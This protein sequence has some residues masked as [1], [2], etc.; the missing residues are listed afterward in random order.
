MQEDKMPTPWDINFLLTDCKNQS[1]NT[2]QMFEKYKKI[3]NIVL[4]LNDPAAD[5]IMKEIISSFQDMPQT[6]T[7]EEFASLE[8]KIRQ[9]DLEQEYDRLYE[10]YLQF[11][12]KIR[13]YIANF[14]L[15]QFHLRAVEANSYKKEFSII[16]EILEQ[17]INLPEDKQYFV[18]FYL[19][20]FAGLDLQYMSEMPKIILNYA[21]FLYGNSGLLESNGNPK[22]KDYIVNQLYLEL[23]SQIS[24]D[25]IENYRYL[26]S[27]PNN[28]EAAISYFENKT[29]NRMASI[30]L[31]S[32]VIDFAY[33]RST[34]INL[35]RWKDPK[36]FNSWIA[37]QLFYNFINSQTPDELIFIGKLRAALISDLNES[38]YHNILTL[39]GAIQDSPDLK[40]IK[41]LYLID[42]RLN[43]AIFSYYFD[44]LN[45]IKTKKPDPQFFTQI[46]ST[47]ADKIPA[48]LEESTTNDIYRIMFMLNANRLN[49]TY[50]PD[51]LL[52]L[53][54]KGTQPLE[55][56]DIVIIAIGDEIEGVNEIS[57]KL[58][59]TIIGVPLVLTGNND[60]SLAILPNGAQFITPGEKGT[61]AQWGGEVLLHN[62]Y[63][64]IN[65]DNK[66]EF[67]NLKPE[68]IRETHTIEEV[69]MKLDSL[70]YKGLFPVLP[71]INPKNQTIYSQDS[72][73][74]QGKAYFQN[75]NRDDSVSLLIA[76]DPNTQRVLTKYLVRFS[77]GSITED[78]IN[79]LQNWVLSE[80][81]NLPK[82]V[83]INI[84]SQDVGRD[85]PLVT[86][87]N[88][89]SMVTGSD[90]L[91]YIGFT[92]LLSSPTPK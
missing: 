66:W 42:K 59:G 49:T 35:S 61:L 34:G 12:E 88:V 65:N 86:K 70:G 17:V 90:A 60:P 11:P 67:R 1:T 79:Q 21:S 14:I 58:S 89:K 64:L 57:N 44:T 54:I 85:V 15:N 7:K 55:Q 46:I 47:L 24:P 71:L 23:P 41:N 36:L 87:G 5:L 52:A 4:M 53:D 68:E 74:S 43:P 63:I 10:L 81:P 20:T 18:V 29:H 26:L 92:P 19:N 56:S 31:A 22:G 51:E 2:E 13:P 8:E 40:Q 37:N 80:N 75:I 82:D 16:Q 32:E 78:N 48:D 3:M 73:D 25:E 69:K 45:R 91:I 27:D 28:F 30:L 76:Y 83:M 77:A 39:Y 84:L 6:Y 72:T 38:G 33:Q 9:F 62:S 50:Q